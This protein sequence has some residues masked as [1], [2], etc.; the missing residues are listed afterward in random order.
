M[1]PSI[2]N[3]TMDRASDADL[4]TV[5]Q[6]VQ[7]GKDMVDTGRQELQRSYDRKL[8]MLNR[9]MAEEESHWADR[10]EALAKIERRVEQEETQRGMGQPEPAVPTPDNA[11]GTGPDS[12]EVTELGMPD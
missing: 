7:F 2:V 8:A 1:I 10:A 4:R 11:S 12:D 3:A 5:T 9:A 6:C